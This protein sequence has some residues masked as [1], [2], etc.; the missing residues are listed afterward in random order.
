MGRGEPTQNGCQFRQ[1]QLK[2]I[3]TTYHSHRKIVLPGGNFGK[4]LSPQNQGF[5]STTMF[6]AA[7]YNNEAD[8]MELF[9]KNYA[10]G[11]LDRIGLIIHQLTFSEEWFVDVQDCARLHV[12]ALLH[13]E[14]S[15]ERIFAW[16]SPF[17]WNVVLAEFRKLFPERKFIDDV[18]GLWDDLAIVGPARRAEALLREMGRPGFTTLE[19]SLKMTVESC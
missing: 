17:N 5:R 14:I 3:S 1:V 9:L 19:E 16:A 2:S 11:K 15:G 4:V 8:I 18:P 10:P 7:L 6:A 13:Q 12:A